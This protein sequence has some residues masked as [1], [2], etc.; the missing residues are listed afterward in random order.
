MRRQSLPS[1]GFCALAYESDSPNK[2]LVSESRCILIAT[3]SEEGILHIRI[4]RAWRGVVRKQDTEYCSALF[5]DFVKRAK[6]DSK[7]LFAQLCSLAV[8]PLI[9]YAV[10]NSLAHSPEIARLWETFVELE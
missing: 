2:E 9:V 7:G 8:G 3:C 4:R 6:I 10:G 1:T 5:N